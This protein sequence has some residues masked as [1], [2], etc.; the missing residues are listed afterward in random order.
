[1]R[2]MTTQPEIAGRSE[3]GLQPGDSLFVSVKGAVEEQLDRVLDELA[4]PVDAE[5]AVHTSRKSIKR[6]RALVRLI[7]DSM[8]RDTYRQVN[9]G[10]RDAAR[11]LAPMREATIRLATFDANR[12]LFIGRVDPDVL[13]R[14]RD[15]FVAERDAAYP[16]GTIDEATRSAVGTAIEHARKVLAAWAEEAAQRHSGNGAEEFACLAHGLDRVYRRGREGMKASAVSGDFNEFHEWRKR[17]KYLRYQLEYLNALEPD[18][19][20]ETTERLHEI[21]ARLGDAHDLWVLGNCIEAH[22]DCCM[23]R[24]MREVYVDVTDQK[25]RDLDA[26]ALELGAPIYAEDPKAFVARIRGYWER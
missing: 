19:L 26:G 5:A 23:D 1:M 14:T 4:D 22:P 6:S 12:E 2:V 20:G 21:D 9:R 8:G 11:A 25:R 24:D 16:D 13:S 18:V 15:C 7:R 3:A 17:V 10:L